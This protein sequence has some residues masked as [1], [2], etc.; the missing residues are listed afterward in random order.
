MAVRVC[1]SSSSVV[2]ERR[3]IISLT[4]APKSKTTLDDETYDDVREQTDGFN[5]GLV[6]SVRNKTAEACKSVF[7]RR[8]RGKTASKPQLTSPHVVYDHRTATFHDEYVSLA[9][10]GG[11]IEADYRLPEDMTGTPHGEYLFANDYEVTGAELHRKYGEWHLHIHTKMDVEID[12]PEQATTTHRTVF[13]VDLG[14]DN[15]AVT[16]TETFWTGD[17]FDRWRREYEQRRGDLGG[18]MRICSQLCEKRKA[19]SRCCSTG[20][21]TSWWLKLVITVVR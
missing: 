4:A 5:G 10:T 14:V 2:V 7:K 12:T 21:A 6:Q 18:H 13:S 17:G 1:V 19:G 3:P 8:K 11:R 16:S 20:L 9:T 15:L